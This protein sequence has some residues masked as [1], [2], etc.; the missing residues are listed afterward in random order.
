MIE[1]DPWSTFKD[2]DILTSWVIIGSVTRCSWVHAHVGFES[3]KLREKERWLKLFSNI[4]SDFSFFYFQTII[5]W[6]GK[7]DENLKRRR[8]W[9]Q[10]CFIMSS[11]CKNASDV[12]AQTTN[13]CKHFE[14]KLKNFVNCIYISRAETCLSLLVFA[15]LWRSCSHTHVWKTKQQNKR[16]HLSLLLNN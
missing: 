15:C 12:K 6:G 8:K 11:L 4:S 3:G 9:Y 7:G 10:T 1:P 14:E 2:G 13:I 5:Y 16:K